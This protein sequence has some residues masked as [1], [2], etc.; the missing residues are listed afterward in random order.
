MPSKGL[1]TDK[2]FQSLIPA[3]SNEEYCGLE[4][5]ILADGCR[6]P[7]VLWGD[8]LI[9]GHNRYEIC[10]KHKLPYETCTISSIKDRRDARI[11]IRRNAMDKRN[12]NAY[13]RSVLSLANESDIAA[14]AKEKQR[15]AGGPLPQKSA[16]A[17]INTRAEVAKDAGV[18][19]DTIAKVKVIEAKAPEEVK[20]RLKR[21]EV[22]INRAFLDVRRAEKKRRQPGKVDAMPDG[23]YRVVYAD[24]PWSYGNTG[25]EEYGHAEGHYPSM[26]IAELSEMPVKDLLEDNAVL[27]LWVTSPLLAECFA[28][29]KAWGFK[30]KTSF[31]WDKVKH[32]FGHYNSVRHEFL[33]VCTKGSCTPDDKTLFDSVQTIERS[34]KHSEKP[35]QFR[36]IIEKLYATGKRI[37]LFARKQV[38]GWDVFGNE[39]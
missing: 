17:P 23:K 2:E 30:Y 24:P 31:V 5:S 26:T 4:A 9:D 18:S 1:Q 34:K 19:H 13:Q 37:E 39:C 33:L 27:F 12:L 21:G 28:V 10:Q 22:T 38:D 14:G 25:L 32:N 20:E 8:I 7:L 35:E 16:K 29:I 15:E 36:A 3:L 6:D 11:W